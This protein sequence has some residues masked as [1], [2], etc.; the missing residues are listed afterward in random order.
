M[1]FETF[2]RPQPLTHG[3]PRG[4]VLFDECVRHRLC[5]AVQLAE[6]YG[7]TQYQATTHLKTEN[8]SL[9]D[10]ANRLRA[11][12][13][14]VPLGG[15]GKPGRPPATSPTKPMVLSQRQ[16]IAFEQGITPDELRLFEPW[17][18]DLARKEGLL[19]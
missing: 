2:M 4:K 3:M 18:I 5:T 8:W 16:R 9:R 7:V 17:V 1:S 15:A 12:G 11:D 10:V 14:D 13:Q 19:R 6:W